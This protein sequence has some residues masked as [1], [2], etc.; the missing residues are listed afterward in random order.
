MNSGFKFLRKCGL[1]K[2][3]C[4]A[5]KSAD[6][7]PKDSAGAAGNHSCGRACDIAGTDLRSDGGR[8][9][10]KRTHPFF[11]GLFA[12]KAETAKYLF[13]AVLKLYDLDKTEA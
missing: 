1:G 11:A 8:Q 7:H 6:P 3:R 9:R 10:L 2:D 12:F 4:H 5:K 13:E